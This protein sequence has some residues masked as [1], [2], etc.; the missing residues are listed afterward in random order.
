MKHVDESAVWGSYWSSYCDSMYN[1]R[2]Y[3]N[4]LNTHNEKYVSDYEDGWSEADFAYIRM[5]TEE[6]L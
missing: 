5:F 2:T 4:D 1:Y 3:D 6:K